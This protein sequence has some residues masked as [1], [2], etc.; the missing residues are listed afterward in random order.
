[1]GQELPQNIFVRKH[2]G[3]KVLGKVTVNGRILHKETGWKSVDWIRLTLDKD[4][5]RGVAN[6][7]MNFWI[8]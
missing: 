3:K 5:R 4:Q 7:A 1:M 8:A 6:M 2:E